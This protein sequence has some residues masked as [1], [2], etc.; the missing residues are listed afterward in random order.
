VLT[1]DALAE[2]LSTALGREVRYVDVPPEQLTAGLRSAGLDDWT[3]VALTEL[4]QVFRAHA[5]EVVTD[6]VRKA[7]GRDARSVDEWLAEHRTAFSG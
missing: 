6:E 3:A 5:A 4:Q 1:H 2:R 7:T